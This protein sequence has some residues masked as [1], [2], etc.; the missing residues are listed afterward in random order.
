MEGQAK[1][2]LCDDPEAGTATGPAESTQ[3]RFDA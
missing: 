1:Q 3:L 2:F